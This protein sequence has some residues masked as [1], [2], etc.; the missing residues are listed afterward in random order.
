MAAQRLL[1]TG[2][3]VSGCATVRVNSSSLPREPAPDCSFS[4]ATTCWTLGAR[5]PAP[6]PEIRDTAPDRLLR[7]PPAVLASGADT[8]AAD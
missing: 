3:L 8:T 4:A 1:W 5:V 2:M 7:P 6:Q